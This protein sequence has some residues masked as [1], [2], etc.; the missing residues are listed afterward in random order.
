[1]ILN[2]LPNFNEAIKN[3]LNMSKTKTIRNEITVSSHKEDVCIY[4]ESEKFV[5]YKQK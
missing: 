5:F 4:F 1:M 2:Y 3:P